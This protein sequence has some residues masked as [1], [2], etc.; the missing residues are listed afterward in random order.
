MPS[1]RG[2]LSLCSLSALSV[3]SGCTMGDDSKPVD[4]RLLN[5]DTEE[6]PMKVAIERD[7][8]GEIFRTEETIPAD[9][10][11]DL[12]EVVIEDAFN[13][14]SDDQFTVRVWLNGEQTGTFEYEITCDDDNRFNL[15]IEH[16]PY[17]PDDGEPVA[18][19][20]ARCWE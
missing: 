11:E 6:W 5:D 2:F 12:G 7:T 4:L 8:E 10:G 20:P 15:L 16:R 17:N 18:Y 1:R 14:T 9:N 3:V 19:V 13:G